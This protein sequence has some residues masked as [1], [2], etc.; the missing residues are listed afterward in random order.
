MSLPLPFFKTKFEDKHIV[1]QKFYMAKHN[2]E[3][4]DIMLFA[5]EVHEKPNNS[6]PAKTA[7]MTMPSLVSAPPPPRESTVACVENGGQNKKGNKGKVL[8]KEEE[9]VRFPLH[10]IH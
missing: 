3:N 7:A 4:R 8:S 2:E 10:S 1:D 5:N 6:G 9:Q